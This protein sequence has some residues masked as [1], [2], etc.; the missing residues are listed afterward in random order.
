MLLGITLGIMTLMGLLLS[1][2]P[3]VKMLPLGA[4][5]G[6]MLIVLG[7]LLLM[8]MIRRMSGITLVPVLLL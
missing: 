4:L 1:L 8:E 6:I 5:L 3:P 2:F 7:I